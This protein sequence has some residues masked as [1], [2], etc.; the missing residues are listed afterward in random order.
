MAGKSFA[1]SSDSILRWSGT[2][3]HKAPTADQMGAHEQKTGCRVLD[4]KLVESKDG[5]RS[6]SRDASAVIGQE[7]WTKIH[8][9]TT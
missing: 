3:L 1:S 5:R 7:D 6:R 9:N 2:G 8:E 4:R